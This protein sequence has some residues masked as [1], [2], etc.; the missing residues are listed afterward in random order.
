MFTTSLLWNPEQP[1]QAVH[2]CSALHNNCSISSDSRAG[3]GPFKCSKDAASI[4]PSIMLGAAGA[5]AAAR[6]CGFARCRRRLLRVATA[7]DAMGK[8]M[9]YV[10]P[11]VLLLAC[12]LAARLMAE[13]SCSAATSGSS[14][15]CNDGVGSG[16]AA[17]LSATPDA[18]AGAVLVLTC[19]VLAAAT[20]AASST[21]STGVNATLA[22]GAAVLASACGRCGPIACGVLGWGLCGRVLGAAGGAAVGLDG[23]YLAASL[24]SLMGMYR[25]RGRSVPLPLL[26]PVLLCLSVLPMSLLVFVALLVWTFLRLELLLRRLSRL[27]LPPLLVLLLLL[28][29]PP[30]GL[31]ILPS[32]SSAC[33]T[34]CM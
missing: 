32:C 4:A 9:L 25:I 19:A 23:K 5:T 20:P 24:S 6:C 1:A 17:A 28:L 29:L 7:V 11:A 10:V 13:A 18:T 31:L 2:T 27:L 12:W 3:A 14:C 21:G 26:L 22:A 16:A 33:W 34:A 15:A 8:A 30:S